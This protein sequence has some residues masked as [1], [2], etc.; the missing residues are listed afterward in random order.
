M[1]IKLAVF[2]VNSIG[3]FE[4]HDANCADC[5]RVK[6]R[7]GLNFHVAEYESPIEVS[8]DIWSD[9]IGEGSMT[10]EDG[11]HEIDFKP[12][13]KWTA[14]PVAPASMME[15]IEAF[16]AKFQADSIARLHRDGLACEGNLNNAKTKVVPGLKYA[17]VNIGDSGR[18]M[19]EMSTGNIFGIK[20]YGQIH[21]GHQYGTVDTINDWDFGGYY[22]VKQ[23]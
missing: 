6:A 8:K 15:K 9:M 17:K 20:G 1:K 3:T 18:F 21:R 12:C 19:V 16:A 22:P 14:V 5:A 13:V 23:V 7:T 4:V 2:D 10:A 11:L